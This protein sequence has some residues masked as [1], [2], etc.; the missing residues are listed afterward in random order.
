[1]IKAFAAF[2]PGGPLKPF[3][4]D[5]GPMGAHDVEIAVRHCGICHSDVSMIDNAWHIAQ[6]PIVPG[7]EV[8]GTVSALGQ[9][10]EK[11][12]RGTIGGPGLARGLLHDLQKLP[13][14]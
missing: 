1:M 3:E 2:E 13:G 8:V 10:G 4:Y 11:P 7:H 14:G 5:P 9:R 6:Y 12:G